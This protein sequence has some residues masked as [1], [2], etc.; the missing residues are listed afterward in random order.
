MR[1]KA[2]WS[3]L[4]QSYDAGSEDKAPRLG[5][6]L[7]YYTIFSLAPLLIILIGIAGFLFGEQAA[8]G[9]LFAQL[10]NTV[11]STAAS[12]IED[13]LKN[14][15]M[16]G[17]GWWATVIAFVILLLG[18]TGLF[19]QLQD[20]L[21]TI[22]KVA[23]KPGRPIWQMVRERLFSFILVLGTG[24]LL[25]ALLLVSTAL[26]ALN[27]FL[28]PNTLPGST[29]LW[30]VV[31]GLVS[32]VFCTLLCA[33]IYK[34]LLDA[35]IAWRDVWIGAAVT[36]LLFTAG[37]Y[38]IGLYLGKSGTAS[39]FGAAGSLVATLIWIYYSAQIF[40]FGA[41]FTRI[42]ADRFG[43]QVQPTEN[44]VRLTP[45]QLAQQG[46]ARTQ[47]IAAAA[48]TSRRASGE[49][50]GERRGLSPPV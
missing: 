29:Y 10:K 43:S 41:E 44:A 49:A 50:S 15:Q 2:L 12:A 35:R 5:A 24:L 14:T 3:L 47:D 39:A 6:A 37:K 22:W 23:P 33:M 7:A 45:E 36:A 30:Q 46:M 13:L 26:T 1:L 20:A 4:K 17:G 21:N 38:L 42:Y 31:N 28:P 27:E 9:Q 40:L 25:L 48:S 19:G 8:R 16:T 34:I 18:A 32:F 11:G